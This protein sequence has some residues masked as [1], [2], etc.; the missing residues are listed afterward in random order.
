MK[1]RNFFC[2]PGNLAAF[3]IIS[4]FFVGINGCKPSGKENKEGAASSVTP[5]EGDAIIPF[6]IK[7]FRGSVLSLGDLKGRPLVLNFWAS[8]C[9]P[10][11]IEASSIERNYLEFKD[12]GVE[13]VGVAVQDSDADARKFVKKFNWTF[14]VGMDETGEIASEYKL[15]GIPKTLVV[16]RDGRFIFDH[17]G[18]ISEDELKSAIM[19]AL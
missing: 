8:W 3:I 1:I 19:K 2:Y 12:R 9:G 14:S 6:K 11:K 15:Y 16:G 7:T 18:A 17:T 13:F 5:G 4:I 10:C